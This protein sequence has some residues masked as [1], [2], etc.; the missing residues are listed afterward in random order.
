MKAHP[1]EWAAAT[2][3]TWGASIEAVQLAIRNI[4]LRWEIDDAYVEQ[5]RVLGQQLEELKQIKKQPDY[6][7][8][9]ETR[10]V[11]PLMEARR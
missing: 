5:A 2:S 3:K 7:A 8:L 4:S 9:F 1:D 10:F 6:R 11:R